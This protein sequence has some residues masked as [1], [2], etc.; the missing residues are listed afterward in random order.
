M[1]RFKLVANN[2]EGSFTIYSDELNKVIEG[3]KSNAPTMF[4]EGMVLN[5]NTYSG[6]VEDVDREQQILEHRKSNVDFDEPSPFAKLVLKEGVI[7][8]LE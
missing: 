8:R 1:K 3:K 2:K 7:K 6:V 5:W 4:K